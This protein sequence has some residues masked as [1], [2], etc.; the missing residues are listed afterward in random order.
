MS[1]QIEFDCLRGLKIINESFAALLRAHCYSVSIRAKRNTTQL[2]PCH[3]LF[4]LLA[5]NNVEEVD[6]FVKTDRAHQQIINR[7]KRY[8]CA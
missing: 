4:D 3:Y 7:A 5:L 1:F 2:K 6:F 8:T